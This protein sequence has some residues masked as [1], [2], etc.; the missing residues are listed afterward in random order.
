M[1]LSFKILIPTPTKNL[2]LKFQNLY[3]LTNDFSIESILHTTFLFIYYLLF[4][5]LVVTYAYVFVLGGYTCCIDSQELIHLY[6]SLSLEQF[7]FL[8]NNYP[9][10]VWRAT[11]NSLPTKTNLV[12]RQIITNNT[13][14][15][16]QNHQEDVGHALYHCPSLG[17]LSSKIPLWN[18]SSL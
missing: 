8:I 15:L 13:C 9:H 3:I 1:Y 18:H 5:F 11:K 4:F 17:E 2:L 7:L 12:K 10:L 16:C 6:D 14:E